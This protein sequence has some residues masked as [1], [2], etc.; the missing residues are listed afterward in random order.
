MAE[1]GCLEPIRKYDQR[2]SWWLTPMFQSNLKGAA[3][4]RDTALTLSRKI[5][6]LR[7]QMAETVAGRKQ[8]WF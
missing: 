2:M 7:Q 1:L 6:W 3:T 5:P 4:V 8:K